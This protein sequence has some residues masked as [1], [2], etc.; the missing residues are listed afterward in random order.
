MRLQPLI[1]MDD[2]AR[3]NYSMES[4]RAGYIKLASLMMKIQLQ[5]H[6]KKSGYLL[7]GSETF[8]AACRMEAEEAPVLLGNISVGEKV[9]EKYLGDILHS[10]GLSASV[11][12]TIQS[13]EGRIRGAIYE[14]RSLTEDF[15]IQS[16]GGCQFALDLYEACIVSSLLSN[17]GTWVE[18]SD[19]SAR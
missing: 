10:Q 8:K 6:P 13:R 15:R 19:E 18:I 9:S 2:T 7:F 16:V 12:A 1:Y 5:V 3:A 17:A 11:K 4:M 14:L